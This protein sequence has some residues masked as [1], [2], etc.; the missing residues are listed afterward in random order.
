MVIALE[1][2]GQ[3]THFAAY[4]RRGATGEK[5][6]LLIAIA[7]IKLADH[8]TAGGGNAERGTFFNPLAGR[9]AIRNVR[10]IAEVGQGVGRCQ[11]G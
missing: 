5:T 10:T 9:R 3:D 8:P 4:R 7:Q 6:G 1:S 2:S 11:G